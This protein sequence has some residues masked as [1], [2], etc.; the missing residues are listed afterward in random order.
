MHN[1][2]KAQCG[3]TLV[4]IMIV[5]AIISLLTAIAIPAFLQYRLDTQMGLCL[6]NLRLIQGALAA[7]QTKTGSYP[8]SLD[9]VAPYLGTLPV[10]GLG[11]AYAA[12]LASDSYHIICAGHAPDSNHVCIH[13]DQ[14]PMVK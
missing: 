5:V 3:F 2:K 10:C 1:A 14:T 9:A 13:E 4:E 7:Y 11:G 8:N 6:A 12:T